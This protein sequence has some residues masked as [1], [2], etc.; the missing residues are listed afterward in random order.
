MLGAP[1]CSLDCAGLLLPQRAAHGGLFLQKKVVSSEPWD[2][3]DAPS[4]DVKTC[5]H[6]LVWGPS[7][8]PGH[9]QLD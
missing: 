3:W 2:L 6:S 4:V 9:L 1:P 8:L 7:T 5:G